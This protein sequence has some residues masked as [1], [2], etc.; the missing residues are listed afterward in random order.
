MGKN[1]R[2]MLCRVKVKSEQVSPESFMGDG[3][4]HYCPDIGREYVHH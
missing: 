1:I 2:V 4:R 3:E